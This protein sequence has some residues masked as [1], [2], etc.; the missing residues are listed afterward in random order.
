MAEDDRRRV[1]LYFQFS[2]GWQCQFLEAD[3]KT[4]LPRKPH[5]TSADKVIELLER[6]GGLT[7]QESRLM[8][9]QAITTGR[10]GVLLSLTEEQYAKLKNLRL[11]K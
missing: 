6:G 9:D 8:L 11:P 2:N 4:S 3:L 1:Y 10:G 7:D 5:F